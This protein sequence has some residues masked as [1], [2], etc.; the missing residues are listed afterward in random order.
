[1]IH[2]TAIISNKSKISNN[3]KIGPYCVIDDYVEIDEGCNLISHVYKDFGLKESVLFADQLM[4]LGFE[5]ST[6]SGASIGVNDFEIPPN[7]N[8]IGYLVSSVRFLVSFSIFLCM[9]KNDFDQKSCI[10]LGIPKKPKKTK[11]NKNY[12]GN[13]KKPNFY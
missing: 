9:Q 6:I 11:K 10:S 1:M 13:T 8:W 7:R 3:V 4:Y 2:P 5:Y 12:I